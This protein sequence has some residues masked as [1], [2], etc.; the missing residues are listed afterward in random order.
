M[1]VVASAQYVENIVAVYAEATEANWRTPGR[2]GS[3]VVLSPEQAGEVMITG[4]LHGHRRNFNLIRRLSGLDAHPRRHLVLQEACHGGPVY[5]QN[6]GCMSHTVLEDIA[7]LKAGCP[8]GFAL[9][10]PHQ[11]ILDGCGDKSCHVILPTDRGL[12]QNEV[13]QRIQRLE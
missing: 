11:I 1:K 7:R 9:P 2:Q 8:E 5:P 12:S 10:N 3:V 13:V 4:D 6:G